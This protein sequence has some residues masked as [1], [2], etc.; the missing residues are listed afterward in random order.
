MISDAA[1]R[2]TALNP[3]QS[4]IVQAPAGSGKTGLLVF[5]LLT[6]LATVEQP[7]QILAITFTR[8]ATSEMRNRVLELLQKAE[9]QQSSDDD[10][11]QTGIDLAKAALAQ[12]QKY[13]W[14]LLDAPHQLQILTIDSFCAKLTTSMPWLSRLGDRPRTTD[15]A[16][17][18]YA[19]AVEQLLSELLRDPSSTSKALQTVLMELDFNYYSARSLFSSML[20]KRDQWLRHL[21]QNDLPAL[22]ETLESTWK[23]IVTEQL[24]QRDELFPQN[25]KSE[26]VQLAL[27]AADN[28]ELKAKGDISPLAAFES[29]DPNSNELKAEQWKGLR[30]LLLVGDG[31]SYRKQISIKIGFPPSEKEAKQKLKVILD[32]L[33]DDDVLRSALAATDFL[34]AEQFNDDDWQQLLA[35]EQVLK[36][37]AAEL[38][39]RFQATGECDHSEVTQRA[40]LALQ[41]LDKP[42]DLGLRLDYQLQHILVDEFQDTSHGQIELLKR[43]TAGWSMQND[44]P[45]RTLFLVGD[46]MQSVYRF[47]EADV[48]LFLRV[49]DNHKTQVFDNIEINSLSLTENFRSNS[50]LVDWFNQTFT[51]SFPENN[52]V[53]TGAIT[54]AQA[55]SSKKPELASVD[56]VLGHDKAQEAEL[57]TQAVQK[58]LKTLEDDDAKIAILVRSRPALK[59]LLPSLQAANIA[60]VGVDIKPLSEGQ[61]VIDIMSLCKAICRE[62]DR[63]SWLALLRGPWC[64]L[65]LA[66]I[67]DLTAQQDQTIWQQLLI[68][69]AKQNDQAIPRLARFINI[70]QQAMEQRQQ[71]ELSSLTYWAWRALGGEQTLYGANPEDITAV[72]T[73]IENLQRGGDLP[74]INDLETALSKLYALPEQN[75]SQDTARVIVSTIHKAK[76]LQYDTVI[77]PGLSRPPASDDKEILMWSEH[78]NKRG[79]PALLLAPIRIQKGEGSHY[80]YLRELEKQRSNNETIRLMYV[81]CT[82][83][84]R[85]LVLIANCDMDEETQTPKPPRKGSLLDTLWS[86]ISDSFDYPLPPNEQDQD[87]TNISQTLSRLPAGFVP[88]TLESVD[89]SSDQQLNTQ[90]DEEKKNI[91]YDWATKVA[92]GVGIV[93]HEW[94]QFCGS[95]VLTAKVDQ[96]LKSRWRNELINLRVPADR[97]DYALKRLMTAVDN[98]QADAQTRFVFQ[99]Y[100]IQHNEYALSALEDTAVK[101]YF[102]DRTF[103]DEN[104]IRWIVDYKSTDTKNDDIDTFIDQ[105]IAERHRDQLEKYGELMSNIESRPIKLA[106]YFPVLGKLRSWDYKTK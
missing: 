90:A 54:Y 13:G 1:A 70:M 56:F 88:Q 49:A 29:F 28:I 59:L 51:P 38:Q 99:D 65:S 71:V 31:K 20:A 12:D 4:F 41:E 18:H 6:L 17:A 3:E 86:A 60:Y 27:F 89:F 48:S 62:D 7:Q 68:A 84:K 33:R 36:S 104:D 103:V 24:Q 22:R 26:L 67:K 94:L 64:G 52:N 53:L 21:L 15:Q 34:P 91:E 78:Q 95:G 46:P 72:L 81:A 11:E 37:L 66:E 101:K 39:L 74:S 102:I 105:Q 85:K 63:V 40:N 55:S 25:L 16:D 100:E 57:L 73:L 14:K 87:L 8:K 9:A 19:A 50:S 79:E 82:R 58:A 32:E 106:I 75:S 47:R 35:L 69:K 61:A 10:F 45:P 5:R 77:L 98:I 83:A 42:T 30:N 96:Q 92:K 2:K 43:L 44:N 97:V 93:L 80:N 23:T 76:G